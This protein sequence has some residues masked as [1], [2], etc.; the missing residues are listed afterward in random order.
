MVRHPTIQRHTS[1]LCTGREHQ[2]GDQSPLPPALAHERAS[3]WIVSIRPAMLGHALS[4]MIVLR[5]FS[6]IPRA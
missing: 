4:K 1:K 6:T 5:C 3:D 2:H